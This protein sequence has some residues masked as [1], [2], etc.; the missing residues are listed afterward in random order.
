MMR[1]MYTMT[2]SVSPL[3]SLAP[4]VWII[5]SNRSTVRRLIP[6]CKPSCARSRVYYYVSGA[7]LARRCRASRS[8]CNGT[9]TGNSMLDSLLASNDRQSGEKLTS[10]ELQDQVITLLFAG[11]VTTSTLL[12]FALY[13]LI[14][15]PAVLAKAYAEADRVLGDVLARPPTAA[16]LGQ[17]QYISQILKETLRLHP[18]V[19]LLT[20]QTIKEEE[21]LGGKYRVTADQDLSIL[22][23]ALHLDPSIWGDNAETFQPDRFLPDAEVKIP[24]NAYKP[25]GNG[26]RACLGRAFALQEAPLVLGMLLQ[27]FE[28]IDHTGYQ[29][30][31]KERVGPRPEGFKIQIRR[32]AHAQPVVVAV[33]ASLQATAPAPAPAPTEEKIQVKAHHT[34]LFVLFGSNLGTAEG[35]AQ[36][37]GDDAR[38]RGFTTAVAPLDGVIDQLNERPGECALVVVASSYNGNPPD[39]ATRFY[40]W[41]QKPMPAAILMGCSSPGTSSYGLLWPVPSPWISRNSRNR[42]RRVRSTGWK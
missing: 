1:S 20:V 15:H 24:A 38:D 32:R 18:P 36:R 40:E 34:P 4:V 17:L 35:L 6:S 11:H 39:N 13:E 7:V 19:T 21:T 25:F 22:V 26:V 29:L 3:I 8:R 16:Q 41:L 27:H 10:Q 5:T 30:K 28:F 31:I 23:P 42:Q 9:G 12:S 37:I 2:W 14:R 33:P